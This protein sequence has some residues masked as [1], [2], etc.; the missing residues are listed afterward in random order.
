MLLGL[1]SYLVDILEGETEGLVGGT[2][3]GLDAVQALKESFAIAGL[4][5]LLGGPSL[6]PGHV[7]GL[8]QHVVSVPSGDGAEGHVVGVVTDLLDVAGHLL[9]DLTETGLKL[10]R[11]T[12]II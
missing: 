7:L 4:A 8:L 9:H 2:L 6:E 12:I 1:T 10:K 3:G 5:T 11:E